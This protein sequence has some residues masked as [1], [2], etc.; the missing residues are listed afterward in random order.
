MEIT[1]QEPFPVRAL[2]PPWKAKHWEAWAPGTEP[3]I[4]ASL[5]H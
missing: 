4:Q 2:L 5:P 1:A 3:S